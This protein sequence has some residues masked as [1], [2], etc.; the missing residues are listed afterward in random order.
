MRKQTYLT[1]AQKWEIALYCIENRNVIQDADPKNKKEGLPFTLWR[2]NKSQTAKEINTNPNMGYPE[3]SAHHIETSIGFYNEV[4]QLIKRWPDPP[5]V[6]D[7]V[8]MDRMAAII[9]KLE[10]DVKACNLRLQESNKIIDAYKAIFNKIS[11]LIPA[12][13]FGVKHKAA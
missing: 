3:I 13:V 7:T 8:E 9:V 11:L 5:P 1:N 2:V 6:Q 4:C 12:D 10:N